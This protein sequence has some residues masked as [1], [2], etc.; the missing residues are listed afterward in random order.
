MLG[1]ILDQ[2]NHISTAILDAHTKDMR[3]GGGTGYDA[4]VIVTPFAISE[5]GNLLCSI[6]ECLVVSQTLKYCFRFLETGLLR[7]YGKF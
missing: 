2:S 4:G 5:T 6:E 7:S 3:I 1:Q